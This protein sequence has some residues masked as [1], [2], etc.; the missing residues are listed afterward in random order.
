MHVCIYVYI[1]TA[2]WGAS[3]AGPWAGGSDLRLQI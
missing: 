1:D 2:Y 3:D